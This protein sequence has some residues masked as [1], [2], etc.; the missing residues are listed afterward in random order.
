MNNGRY[1]SV[2]LL[3][4]L[5]NACAL[6]P[7]NREPIEAN[8]S[9]LVARDFVAALAKLNGY[10]PRNT[11]VQ[12]RPP[13]TAFAGSLEKAIRTAGFG[14]QMIPGNDT[15]PLL[16]SYE[17]EAF[18]NAA[19]RSV[20]YRLRVGSVELSREYEI[21]AGRVFP[22]TGMSV[23]GVLISSDPLD[24]TIF[25]RNR[26]AEQDTDTTTRINESNPGD[27]SPRAVE[28][29]DALD[30][31]QTR[32]T[33][34]AKKTPSAETHDPVVIVDAARVEPTSDDTDMRSPSPEPNRNGWQELMPNLVVASV[35][36]QP[37]QVL[38]TVVKKNVLELGQSNFAPLL[39][40]YNVHSET[41]LVFPND[42]L[43]LGIENKRIV[44]EWARRFNPDTDFIS[45]IGCSH[46]KSNIDSGNEFLAIGRANRVKEALIVSQVP[47]RNIL[48][49]GCWAPTWQEN[50]PARGVMLTHRR[51]NTTG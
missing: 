47:A 14:I 28:P 48:D 29:M 20:G 13:K 35:S 3:A 22:M 37:P 25:D 36:A 21:R 40:N 24:Q 41:V 44:R 50:L 19:G 12:L 27:D 33:G 18:E 15:G 5:L 45:V 8:Q 2:P 1:L 26:L 46:G 9:A 30:P 16:V 7:A 11:T 39:A 31:F 38:D 4:L 23:K 42:S 10:S 43:R 32:R 6:L 49:E 34:L 51:K 17:S